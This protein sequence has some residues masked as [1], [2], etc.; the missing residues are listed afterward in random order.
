ME[1]PCLILCLPGLRGGNKSPPGG[2]LGPQSGRKAERFTIPPTKCMRSIWSCGMRSMP[3]RSFTDDS[4]A[5]DHARAACTAC[6]RQRPM[7][8]IRRKLGSGGLLSSVGNT[9]ERPLQK[10]HREF[11]RVRLGVLNMGQQGV[12]GG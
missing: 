5:R 8:Q 10:A 1:W 7:Y 6:W 11:L 4:R 12:V 3:W 9:Q 2:A